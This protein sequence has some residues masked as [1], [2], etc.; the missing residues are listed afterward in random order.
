MTTFTTKYLQAN[1][2]SDNEDTVLTIRRFEKTEMMQDDKTV[3]KWVLHFEEIEAGLPLNDTNG[4]EISKLHSRNMDS[5]LGK[6]I[7]LYVLPVEYNCVRMNG[8]RVR[9]HV[10]A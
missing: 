4:R 1:D 2:L 9:P 10:P 3:T 5:W 7:A 6:R 8:I